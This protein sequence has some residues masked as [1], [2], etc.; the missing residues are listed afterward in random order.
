MVSAV[1]AYFLVH[2][3]I[4]AHYKTEWKELLILSI[5]AAAS[6]SVKVRLP[7]SNSTI[8]VAYAFVFT[9]ILLLGPNEAILIAAVSQFAACTLKVKTKEYYGIDRLMFNIGSLVITVLSAYA[10]L[11]LFDSL[12]LVRDKLEFIPLAVAATTYFVVNTLFVA[13]AVSLSETRNVL[14][15]WRQDSL[16]TAPSFFVGASIAWALT[17]FY[18]KFGIAVVFLAIPP[19]YLTYFTHKLYMGR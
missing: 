12:P 19:L 15:V 13:V 9:G 6:A 17:V 11:H 3:V 4:S 16:W 10:S 18:Q 2:S 8:S 1:G 7:S 14:S 5:F